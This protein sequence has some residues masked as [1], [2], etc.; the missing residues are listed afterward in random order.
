MERGSIPQFEVGDHRNFFVG[1]DADLR[2][3]E[4]KQ[5][6]TDA[7][8]ASDTALGADSVLTFVLAPNRRYRISAKLF[9]TDNFKLRHAGPA[10]PTLVQIARQFIGTAANTHNYDVVYSAGDINLS[11]GLLI[12]DG[13]IHNGANSG[14]FTL[15]WAQ[16]ASNPTPAKLYA[17][18]WLQCSLLA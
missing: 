15:Q 9:V 10:A 14:F 5:R 7:S 1:L 4:G 6:V 13:I 8:K 2:V 16:T 17:G 11:Q 3:V 18:S 12:L